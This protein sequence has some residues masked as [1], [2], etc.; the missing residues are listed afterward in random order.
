MKTMTQWMVTLAALLALTGMLTGADD[1][2]A[3]G[4]TEPPDSAK[5]HTW[6]HWMNG[7]IT[8]AGITADLEAMKKAGI[9]GV[10]IFNAGYFPAGPVN[11]MGDE[12]RAMAKHAIAEAGRLGLTVTFHNC[13][14]WS[15]SGG[16]WNTPEHGM[17][18]VV[19]S[20]TNVTGPAKWAGTLA[21]PPTR[22]NYYRDIAV[23]AVRA[24]SPDPAAVKITGSD[25][26]FSGAKIVDG[27]QGSYSFLPAPAAKKPQSVTFEY[28]EPFA[29]RSLT[30]HPAIGERSHLGGEL[31]ISDDG[32]TFTTV[33][34]FGASGTLLGIG[35][36]AKPSRFYRMLFTR[37]GAKDR[38]ITLSEIVLSGDY[39]IENFRA[40]AGYTRSSATDFGKGA[41]ADLGTIAAKGTTVDL[42]GSMKPD[43]SLAWDIPAGSWTIIRFGHTANMRGNHPAPKEGTG[44]ECDKLSKEALDAHWQGMM[45]KVVDDSPGAAGK[46]LVGA[47]ID[48]YEVGCQ[49]WTPKFREEFVKRRGYDPLPYLPTITGRV[50]DNAK[51]TERFLWDFRRTIAEL[52]DDYYYGHFAEL[53]AKNNL[54]NYNEPYGNG[55]FNELESGG[56]GDMPMTE[57]WTPWGFSAAGGKLA[58]SIAHT[59]GKTYVGAE[60]FTATP[61]EGRW[62]Q[63]PF[64]LKALGDYQQCAG[65]N[66]FIFHCYAHQPWTNVIPGMTM[67][68]WG[69]HFSRTATWWDQ[70]NG[71]FRYLARTQFIHQQGLF[72]ADVCVFAG[73]E[74]PGNFVRL[75]P[76]LPRGYDYDGFDRKVLLTRMTVKDGR[77]VLPDGMSY[78]YMLLPQTDVMT[79]EVAMKIRDLVS[80]GAVVIG[81]RP[82][83]SPSLVNYPACDTALSRIADELWGDCDGVKIKERAFG[84]GKIISGKTFEEIFAAAN[85]PPD[86][87]YTAEKST[88][89]NYIHRRA[90]GAEIYFVANQNYRYEET[91]CTFRVKGMRPEFWRPDTG[92]I[93]RCAVYQETNG[94]TVIPIR[95]D[96]AGAVFVVF[97]EKGAGDNLVSVTR[98][99]GSV[100][101]KPKADIAVIKAVY[102]AFPQTEQTAAPWVDVTAKLAAMVKDNALSVKSGNDLAGDPAS[103]VVKELRVEYT[104]D[105]VKKTK[106]VGENAML[107]IKDEGAIVIVRARYGLLTEEKETPTTTTTM[108]IT[109]KLAALV[110]DGALT[111]QVNNALA[112]N[113]PAPMT[114]KELRVEFSVNGVRKKKT[115]RENETLTLPDDAPDAGALPSFE[116]TSA[117]E[118]AVINAWETGTYTL[119][120]ANGRT[121]TVNVDAIPEPLAISGPWDLAFQEGRGAPEQIRLDK[122][123]SWSEHPDAGVRYFSGVGTYTVSFTVP[124]ELLRA[125]RRL[126]L[127]LGRVEVSAAA[128]LN[129]KKLGILWKAPYR[130]DVS[131]ALKPGV[132]T[133]TVKAANLWP[134]RLIG[135]EQLPDD[136][137]WNGDGSLKAWPEWLTNGSP[138]TS[139]RLTFTT[140]KHWKKDADL[141]TSGLIGPVVIRVIEQRPVK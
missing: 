114:V 44:L 94:R 29:A 4:F 75:K 131:D 97:R 35:F 51:E 124:A 25:P 32:V 33:R 28:A 14:G 141:L 105:G 107:T 50:V 18:I 128:I 5:P 88:K 52:F 100:R 1:A 71:W 67:G 72:A 74:A 13:A 138:R 7:T 61:E 64:N 45:Q 56:Y 57:F 126:V 9:G 41:P 40:K 110:K 19:T 24:G 55:N 83:M 87:E 86:F 73:E 37:V 111:A 16:P 120:A 2:L 92:M 62:M 121:A 133:L 17:Q 135:D 11:F 119:A 91:V 30:V 95:F 89:L 15:S 34:T 129:G 137:T 122:L 78:R 101:V 116:I 20:E 90:G 26:K 123:I 130:V 99:G 38:Q 36:N 70:A 136:C 80:A 68:P 8:K 106:T 98:S 48:S 84:K 118:G 82:S 104:A 112:G 79:P 31:Q 77:I 27:N 6:W 23:L 81:P 125:G 103:G 140:W 49:N 109:E 21:Q 96:T 113:D 10:Q 65:I 139:G 54:E 47:L 134:N 76:E 63:H 85:L 108:D 60:S 3:K 46:T 102:G 132:N 93:E 39:R 43:G 69:T 115:I 12:W 53:C 59:Y 22:T 66:R 58:S 117:A 127:D 42:T